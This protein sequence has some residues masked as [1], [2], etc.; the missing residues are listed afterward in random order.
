MQLT[1][2]IKL[3][4]TFRTDE[5]ALSLGM[6][7]TV[8]LD[9]I[10]N[11]FAL[12]MPTGLSHYIVNMAPKKAIYFDAVGNPVRLYG[13]TQLKKFRTVTTLIL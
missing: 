10:E 2:A 1:D 9:R 8:D 12:S 7:N 6:T 3:L 4:K 5:P 11:E 13:A